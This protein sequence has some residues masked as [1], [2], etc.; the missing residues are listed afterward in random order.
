MRALAADLHCR[1]RSSRGLR[2]PRVHHVVALQEGEDSPEKSSSDVTT[3][4]RLSYRQV[5][6]SVTYPL[7]TGIYRISIAKPSYQ[8]TAS[9][10]INQFFSGE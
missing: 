10:R 8:S 6:I 7:N 9:L 2:L 3:D 4:I 1:A 5:L